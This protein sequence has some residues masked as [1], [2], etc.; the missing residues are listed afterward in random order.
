MKVDDI[1]KILVVGMGAM[2]QKI[3]LQC[4][5]FGYEVVAY[6]P[7]SA[8]LENARVK[9]PAFAADL[10][11]KQKM[12][13]EAS[14]AAL[15]R[16][17]YTSRPE[18][19]ADADLLSESV[20]EDPDLKAKVFAQFNQVCHPKTVFTTNTSTLLPSMYAEATG[21]PARFAALHFYGVFDHQLADVMP[22]PGTSPEIVELLAAFARR[23]K[24]VPLVFKR[25]FPGYVAN[26]I[27]GAM[28]DMAIKI[29]L[30]EKIASVEDVDRA[31][32]LHLE[33]PYGPFGLC[34]HVGLDTVWHIAQSKAKIS[35]D[36]G[37][38]K[39]ADE[40][41]RD[42]IDKGRLGVKSGRGFY[43]YPDPAYLR[44]DFLGGDSE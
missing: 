39:F 34:D 37:A 31:V 42:Y 7:I 29:A 13:P 14:E 32:M 19:G 41:K 22:H 4:A 40:F 44:P 8:S 6:D 10:I 11:E 17:T 9:I 24:Q 16:I 5:R 38:Q 30:V 20:F 1:R 36:P 23:I 3:A 15:S 35:G 28:N 18:E 33:M 43:T 2:G 21:R 27:F 12:T 26:A 25:E